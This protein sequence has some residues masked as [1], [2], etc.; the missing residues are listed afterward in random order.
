MPDDVNSA[1]QYLYFLADNP[2]LL[3]EYKKNSRKNAE[4]H[5]SRTVNTF[6]IIDII[7]KESNISFDSNN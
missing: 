1:L 4:N 7:M 5:F 2:K 6:K 3:I